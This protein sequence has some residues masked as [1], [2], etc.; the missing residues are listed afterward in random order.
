MAH[1]H[2]ELGELR[3]YSMQEYTSTSS[4]DGEDGSPTPS[5]GICGKQRRMPKICLT[6][7]QAIPPH[8]Q[9]PDKDRQGTMEQADQAEGESKG[10]W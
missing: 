5:K 10:V 7:W 1:T 6:E 3:H 8:Y 9:L 2:Y 4:K